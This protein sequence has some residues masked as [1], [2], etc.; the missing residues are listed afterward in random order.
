VFLLLPWA[1]KKDSLKPFHKLNTLEMEVL[2]ESNTDKSLTFGRQS[3]LRKRK[4][5][6]IVVNVIVFII[7]AAAL[8][9]P[10]FPYKEIK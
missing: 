3:G 8:L 1:N 10:V 7:I 4:A 9:A 2:S 5:A 6:L